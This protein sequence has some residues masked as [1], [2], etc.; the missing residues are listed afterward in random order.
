M[1]IATQL[2]LFLANKPG[3]LAAVCRVLSREQ[4]NIWAISTS[5]TVDHMVIRL[6]VD[7]PDQALRLFESHGTLAVETEVLLIEGDNRIG[8]LHRIADTLS[9]HNINI[10][11]A[12]CAT[13]PS[14]KRGLMIMRTANVSKALKVLNMSRG[15]K[16]QAPA[17]KP[18]PLKPPASPGPR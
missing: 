18:R 15:E 9:R 4:I 1:Q 6:I 2:A 5:D 14:A 11:Y 10:E 8:S 3:M 17:K 7:R 13:H 12:Y 16:S